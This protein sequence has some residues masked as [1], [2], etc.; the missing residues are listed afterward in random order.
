M[1]VDM[2][3][4]HERVIYEKLKKQLSEQK[5]I[6]QPLLI[7][8]TIK[9]SERETNYIEENQQIFHQL[10]MIIERI[11]QDAIVVREVPD[12]LRD[13]EIETLIRDIASDLVEHQRSSRLNETIYELLGTIACHAAV[14][15]AR[16]LT[17]PE[18]NALLRAM[19]H[20]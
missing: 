18:M 20:D 4:A 17:I 1:L 2:H 14:R 16:K 3:A 9:L 15:A 6:S 11:S 10:G 5:M 7:P 13:G 12:L 19:E 8:L